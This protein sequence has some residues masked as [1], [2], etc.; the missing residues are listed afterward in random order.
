MAANQAAKPKGWREDRYRR[1]IER[2]VSER[3]RLGLTQMDLATRLDRK[4]HYVSRF[5]TGERRLDVRSSLTWRWSWGSVQA[6]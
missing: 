1:L 2:L 6:N 3:K 4:Q 5:Q